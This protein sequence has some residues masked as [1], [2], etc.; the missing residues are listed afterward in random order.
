MKAP[1][2]WDWNLI[3]AGRPRNLRKNIDWGE[4]DAL[5]EYYRLKVLQYLQGA[6]KWRGIAMREAEQHERHHAASGP[7]VGR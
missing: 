5:E 7:E 4:G 3:R 6:R 1:S 2:R